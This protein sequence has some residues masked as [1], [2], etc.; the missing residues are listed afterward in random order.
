MILTLYISIDNQCVN[1]RI[2]QS[3]ILN[4]LKFPVFLKIL[5]FYQKKY[6]RLYS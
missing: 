6:V 4:D 2:F 1:V 3:R 5:Y